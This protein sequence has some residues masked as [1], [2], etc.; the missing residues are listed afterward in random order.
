MHDLQGVGVAFL[1]IYSA[2]LAYYVH[3]SGIR[4]TFLRPEMRV[5]VSW[6]VG[7]GLVIGASIFSWEDTTMDWLRAVLWL[8]IGLGYMAFSLNAG[9]R[10]RLAD[11]LLRNR[12][13]LWRK[14]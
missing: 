4:H 11:V 3:Y 7:L 2:Y 1:V 6:L 8:L 5:I 14:P 12:S 9:E 13:R 10:A